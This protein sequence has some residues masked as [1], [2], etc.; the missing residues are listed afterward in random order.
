MKLVFLLTGVF[1]LLNTGYL[2]AQKII[3]KGIR[4]K[5]VGTLPENKGKLL[6]LAGPVAG[7]SNEMLIVGGGANFPGS[8]PWKG[9][10]KKYYDNLYAYQWNEK[11][12]LVLVKETVLPIPMAYSACVSTPYGIVI[13]GGENDHGPLRQVWLVK[14]NIQMSQPEISPLPSLPF[15]L[16]AAAIATDGENIFVAGGDK[17]QE[18]SDQLLELSL[19]D[20]EA[21]W[22]EVARLPHAVSHAVLVCL[23]EGKQKG[24]Y[25]IGGRKKVADAPS[26]LY[27]DNDYYNFLEKKWQK[28]TSLP[29]TLSAGTGIAQGNRFIFLFGGDRGETF[30]KTEELI[31]AIAKEKDST[32]K[33]KLIADKAFVQENHP[34]FSKAIWMFDID[35]NTWKTVGDIPFPTPVTTV[36]V[37]WKKD[38]LIP[39]GEVRAGVRTAQILEARMIY[40]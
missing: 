36:A 26:E 8:M 31:V 38:V 10:K 24:L 18:V 15:P 25:L 23:P 17:G 33:E 40:K 14:W 4:W 19:S 28:K 35:S 11:D 6:G 27:R 16:T 2:P 3:V 13:A 1:F 20:K 12:S 9:G 39:G 5:M 30:H 32:L 7:V 34:G 21:G 37:P 22:R 29:Y